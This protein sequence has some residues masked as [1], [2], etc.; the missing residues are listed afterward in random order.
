MLDVAMS[1]VTTARW[2]LP[3]ELAHVTEHGFPALALWRPKVSDVGVATAAG[4]L[5]RFGV[6]ASSLHWAGGFTGSDGR[7]FAESVADAIEAI[8][9]AAALG[10]AGHRPVL[11][12][13]SGCRG[14]HTRTHAVRLLD[15]ALAAILPLADR[16]GVAL[17]LKPFRAAAAPG[18][19]FLTHLEEALAT[20]E[21]FAHPCLRLALDLWQFADDPACEPLLPSLARAAAIVQ[22]ADRV[23]A[24]T[25]DGDRLPVG[26]GDLPLER[27]G[28]GLWAAGYRG[29]LEFDPVGETVETLGYARVLRETRAVT[30]AWS[31]RLPVEDGAETMGP[32]SSGSFVEADAPLAHFAAAE[33]LRGSRRSQASSQVVSPG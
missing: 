30:D 19:S 26:F 9:A 8:E 15:E 5:A 17:A 13:H 24:V 10:T 7:S 29:H 3:R 1:Q 28:A 33:P 14:G 11:V 4:R 23:G 25:P 18:C 16:R 20:V 27:L 12:V 21:R 2:E 22:V 6:R 31:S 32:Q